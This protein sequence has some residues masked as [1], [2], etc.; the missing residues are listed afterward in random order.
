MSVWHCGARGCPTHS[1]PEH[2]CQVG[3]WYCGRRKPTCLG[4]SDPNHRCASDSGTAWHCGARHCPTH[5]R[6]EHHCEVGIWYCRRLQPPCPGHIRPNHQC[7]DIKERGTEIVPGLGVR[8][9]AVVSN[10]GN[11]FDMA[12]AMLETKN[13][14]ADYPL[15][16][17][18]PNKQQKTGDAANFGIFKQNWLMIR[19]SWS[20]FANLGPGDYLQGRALNNNLGM[21][22]QVLHASQNHYGI[23]RLWFSGHRNG[24][25]GLSKPN[26]ADIIRYRDAVYWTRDKLNSQA[27]YLTDDTRFWVDV[28]AI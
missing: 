23:D 2:R 18:Y 5:S 7:P 17:V 14:V 25:S 21:D 19:S 8:K 12:I 3:V 1:R 10:G 28:N 16:D 26:T 4:H 24:G 27:S 9:Q 6:P 15:G 13:M 20:Q 11:V 22:I